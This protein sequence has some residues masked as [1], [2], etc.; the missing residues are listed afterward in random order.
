MRDFTLQI[1]HPESDFHPCMRQY[2]LRREASQSFFES[3]LQAGVIIPRADSPVRTTKKIC[4]AGQPTEPTGVQVPDPHTFLSLIQLDATH[5]TVLDSANPF[6]SIP[7]Q[8]DSTGEKH[9]YLP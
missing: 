3:L 1:I 5:F 2:S 4:D 6:F 7:V 8:K 9:P